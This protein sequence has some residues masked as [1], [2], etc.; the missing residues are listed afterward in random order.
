MKRELERLII[1]EENDRMRLEADVDEFQNSE[2]IFIKSRY[3]SSSFCQYPTASN[4]FSLLLSQGS[5]IKIT[6]YKDKSLFGKKN[7]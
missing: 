7:I 6:R 1:E 3:N 4:S 5:G 2:R